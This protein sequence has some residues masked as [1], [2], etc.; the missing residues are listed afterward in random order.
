MFNKSKFK[1]LIT[2]YTSQNYWFSNNE[3]TFKIDINFDL[4]INWFFSLL[5]SLNK[6]Y[7]F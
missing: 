6:L 7:S 3:I 2:I 4:I 1:L 5:S